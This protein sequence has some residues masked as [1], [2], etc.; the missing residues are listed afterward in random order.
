MARPL[1]ARVAAFAAAL[2]QR[3]T[4]TQAILFYGS[5]LRDADL[6]GLLD[7]YVVADPLSGWHDS[8]AAALANAVLPVSVS[9]VEMT[10]DDRR[11]RAKIAVLSPAQLRRGMREGAIDTTMWARFSQPAACAWARD[12]ATRERVV[13]DLSQ[14]VVTAA[15]WAALLGPA[16]GAAGDYWQALYQHTYAVELRVER[17]GT[18]AKSLLAFDGA[19]YARL[20]PLAWQAGAVA[21][22]E[23]AGLYQ[24][25]LDAALRRAAQRAWWLRRAAGKPLNLARLA[26]AAFTFD[27][28]ADYLAWKIERHSGYKLELSDWQRRHPVL[29]APKVLWRLWRRGVLR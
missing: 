1:D 3:S 5:A 20:L 27:N 10:I 22:S 2:A 13:A 18:R 23:A 4:A 15:R 8:Q 17:G 29:A 7:F 19:R 12:A 25:T 24:P 16:S 6:D 14:A 9:Y 11:L 21:Y 28:G 26:K